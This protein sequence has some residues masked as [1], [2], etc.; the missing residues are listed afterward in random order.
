MNKF[1]I[2][3][4]QNN[5]YYSSWDRLNNKPFN[6][7]IIYHAYML[8]TKEDTLTLVDYVQTWTN[9]QFKNDNIYSVTEVE[10]KINKLDK[11]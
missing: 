9:A 6:T 1:Y 4:N 10:C 11:E 7:E 3:T 8:P 5:Q 2:L